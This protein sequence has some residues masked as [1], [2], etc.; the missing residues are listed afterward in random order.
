MKE[1]RNIEEKH[2]NDCNGKEMV[3]ICNKERWM[4]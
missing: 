1:E 4:G 3:E 2:V